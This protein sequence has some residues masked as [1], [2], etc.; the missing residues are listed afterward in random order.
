MAR[1][2]TRKI[3]DG[4]AETFNSLFKASPGLTV[5][6]GFQCYNLEAID[7]ETKRRYSSELNAYGLT[8]WEAAHYLD[9][10]IHAAQH[11]RDG[12]GYL[13][14]NRKNNTLKLD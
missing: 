4:K 2:M 13:G 14:R 8:N 10:L 12:L 5:V 6:R 7:P 3:L 9:G 1:R 11:C